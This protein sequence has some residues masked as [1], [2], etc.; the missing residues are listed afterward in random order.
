[1]A[2]GRQQRVGLARGG[3]VLAGETVPLYSASVHYWRLEREVWRSAL[4]ETQKLGVR[5]IDTY[6]PWGVHETPAGDMDFGEGDPRRD[7]AAFLQM[8]HELGLLAI[9]RPGPHINAELTFFGLPE[10]IV[11]DPACQ[12]RSPENNPVML[13]MVPVGFPVPSYASEAFL[14]EAEK[15]FALVGPR[16]APFRYPDGPIVLCQ[17]DN[18]AAFYFRDGPY[19]QDYRPEAIAHYRAFLREKYGTEEALSRAYGARAAPFDAV[20]PP[21]IFD[22]A[23]ADELTWHVDW[24][25][26]QERLVAMSLARMK[27]ALARAGLSEI[28]MFHNMTMGYEATP[29]SAARIRRAVDLVGL[30]YYHRAT[31]GERL[32]IERRTTELVTRSDGLDE[33]AFACEMAAGFPPFFFPIHDESDNRFN[34]MTALAYGLRGFNIYMAVERDRWIGAPIDR[35][36]HPRPSSMFWAKLC[37]ALQ[38]VRFHELVRRVPVR[39]V[40]SALKRRLNRA[41]HAFSPATPALFAVLGSGSDESCFEEDFGLGGVTVSETDAFVALFETA[42]SARGIPFAHADADLADASLQ[43]AHWIICPTADGIEPSLWARLKR[44]AAEGTRVTIGPRVPSRDDSLR[45]LDMPLD[46]AGFQVVQR[47]GP[48]PYFDPAAITALVADRV[49]ELGLPSLP[50][51]PPSVFATI[52]EDA[53]ARPRVLFLVNPTT[54]PHLATV[55]LDA[56]AV[57]DLFDQSRHETRENQVELGVP[58]RSVRMLRIDLA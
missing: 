26:F 49:G 23:N 20:L 58:A 33:P 28:P 27:A 17:V 46:A 19:D 21:V 40:N 1:M 55:R 35:H 14:A 37:S 32:L 4:L 13:P 48:H 18:E 30:D 12:A 41:L 53:S 43:A 38:Q 25:E 34:V 2:H 56:A 29:L 50:I 9:V 36:G 24:I 42:L 54:D 5:L 6:V 3:I 45:P 22:A 10:R 7:V 11:W 51:A 39:I 44:A 8:V 52:H 57:T 15:W 31:P 47:V 16:L